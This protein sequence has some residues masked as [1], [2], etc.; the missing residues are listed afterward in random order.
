MGKGSVAPARR[1]AFGTVKSSMKSMKTR[2]GLTT[3]QTHLIS[4]C[5]DRLLS[6]AF[7]RTRNEWGNGPGHC[8][9]EGPFPRS[10]QAPR[11]RKGPTLLSQIAATGPKVGPF[12]ERGTSG[13]MAQH[14]SKHGEG[15]GKRGR[16]HRRRPPLQENELGKKEGCQV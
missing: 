3:G 15:Q 8:M 2:E 16:R 10:S 6:R 14:Q 7:S 9:R 13:E 5:S 1:R 11:S 12:L 4:C